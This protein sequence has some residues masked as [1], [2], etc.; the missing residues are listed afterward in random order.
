M[1]YT[2]HPAARFLDAIPAD[3]APKQKDA[4]MF[5]AAEF[6]A[7]TARVDVAGVVQAW[8]ET[9][10]EDL[11]DGE[12]MSD[13]LGAMLVGLAA[14]DSDGEELSEEES[15]LAMSYMELAAQYMIGLGV[16]EGDAV[17]AL[18]GDADAA[19]RAAEYVASE[20]EGDDG[21]ASLDAFAFS[22]SDNEPAFDSVLDAV[23]KM[24]TVV[25]GGKKLR[26]NK[27]V[28]GTVR[29][30]GLQ[31]VALRKARAKAHSSGAKMRRMKSMNLRNRM[32]IKPGR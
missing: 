6:E 12:S 28:G 1:N 2:N 20:V 9:A 30:S 15:A 10:P 18:E 13:R 23:Y 14:P 16:S 17:G 32:G 22:P 25:R 7:T 3:T 27:R 8:A 4:P 19:S 29:L 11:D 5:D 24:R 26:I 31:R 21:D